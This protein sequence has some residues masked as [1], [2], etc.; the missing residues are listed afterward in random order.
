MC[1]CINSAL[2]STVSHIVAQKYGTHLEIV[3][4]YV[5]RSTFIMHTHTHTKNET[6]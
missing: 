4:L 1:V 5:Q 2:S 6:E 3:D